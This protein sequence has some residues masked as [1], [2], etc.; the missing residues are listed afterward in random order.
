MLNPDQR[1]RGAQRSRVWFPWL[2]CIWR[3]HLWFSC[4]HGSF[5]AIKLNQASHLPYSGPQ[6]RIPMVFY[7]I[8]QLLFHGFPAVHDRLLP[9]FHLYLHA[10][11][12]GHIRQLR[13]AERCLAHFPDP[14]RSTGDSIWL[15]LDVHNG[16][17]KDLGMVILHSVTGNYTL[18]RRILHDSLKIL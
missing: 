11:L 10:S 8:L 3:N 13:E 14:S 4:G 1:R 2:S 7:T 6:L 18:Y 15:L 16:A 9:G 12:G 17:K 5:P